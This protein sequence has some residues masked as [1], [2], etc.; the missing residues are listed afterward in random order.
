MG[1]PTG[2]SDTPARADTSAKFSSGNHA[3]AKPVAECAQLH[4]E[5]NNRFDVPAGA[6]R[7]PASDASHQHPGPRLLRCA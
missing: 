2:T 5:L 3:H 7:N 6:A 1:W 4:G